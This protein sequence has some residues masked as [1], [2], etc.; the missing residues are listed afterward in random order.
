V[1]RGG[2]QAVSGWY[3]AVGATNFS[4][5]RI[6]RSAN[7]KIFPAGGM[8]REHLQRELPTDWTVGFE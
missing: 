3:V 4:N 1:A 6:D 5:Q 7:S 8:S 2:F